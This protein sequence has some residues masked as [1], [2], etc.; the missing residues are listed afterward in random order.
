ME[1]YLLWRARDADQTEIAIFLTPLAFALLLKISKF[2]NYTKIE[3]QFIRNNCE[4][5]KYLK[6]SNYPV[7]VLGWRGERVPRAGAARVAV[8]E[9][10]EQELRTG[11]LLHL[12]DAF[13]L[14]SNQLPDKHLLD[15]HAHHDLIL[16]HVANLPC[17]I[18]NKAHTNRELVIVNTKY[19]K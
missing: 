3:V 18:S 10:V 15:P 14:L 2:K 7:P 12:F 5:G 13:S 4:F 16:I 11:G 19:L 9:I 1:I 6:W 8:R 17:I